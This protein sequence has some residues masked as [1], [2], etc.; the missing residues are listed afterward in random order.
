MWHCVI[1]NSF[2][3][4]GIH[5]TERSKSSKHISNSSRW[6]DL[7]KFWNMKAS[8]VVLPIPIFS[9]DFLARLNQL[10]K[11]FLYLWFLLGPNFTSTEV[12]SCTLSGHCFP[13]SSKHWAGT[14]G[15]WLWGE[16]ELHTP[17]PHPG[18]VLN[19]RREISIYIFFALRA[20]YGSEKQCCQSHLKPWGT[21]P[22]RDRTVTPGLT[23]LRQLCTQLC[24][25]SLPSSISEALEP[26][27]SFRI[28]CP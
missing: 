3:I 10:L 22:L 5:K 18:N 15:L 6:A 26:A 1:F 8:E 14:V 23:W 25:S 19:T 7:I 9:R 12:H 24:H 13:L 4:I 27:G 20:R 21:V 16:E 28:C 17:G 2:F 11:N